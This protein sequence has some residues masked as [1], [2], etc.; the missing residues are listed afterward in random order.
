M[1]RGRSRRRLRAAHERL[2]GDGLCRDMPEFYRYLTEKLSSL[3]GVERIESEPL[4]RTVK[5]LGTVR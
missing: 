4:L 2:G 5:Q 3:D 1:K